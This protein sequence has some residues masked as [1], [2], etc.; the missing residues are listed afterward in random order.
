MKYLIQLAYRSACLVVRGVPRADFAAVRDAVASKYPAHTSHLVTAGTVFR[1]IRA[2]LA[3]GRAAETEFRNDT[4]S[5]DLV[6]NDF[7]IYVQT[8]E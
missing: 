7:L 5:D 4:S 2:A 1:T 3:Q 8:S 6:F